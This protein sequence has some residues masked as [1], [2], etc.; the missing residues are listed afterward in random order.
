M[1]SGTFIVRSRSRSGLAYEMQH[2]PEGYAVH[3]G[4]GCEGEIFNGPL[5]CWHSKSHTVLQEDIEDMTTAV[6]NY[7]GGG[8]VAE[9][10]FNEDDLA[11]L[12][13]TICKGA[14]DAELKLFIAT[15]QH[16]GLDPFMKQIHCVMRNTKDGDKWV[17]AMTIQIGI[18]G[19]RLIADR[20]SQMEG[21]DGPQWT[22]D[23]ETWVDVP[24]DMPD[25]PMAARVGIYRK[26]IMRPFV[27]VARWS[28][29]VQTTSNG[30]PNSVWA[31]RGP[32]QLAKC[33]EAL[34]LRRAFPAEIT[35]LPQNVEYVSDLDPEW[36]PEQVR[37]QYVTEHPNVIDVAPET[38]EPA[39]AQDNPA[40]D[41]EPETPAAQNDLATAQRQ[42][43]AK[44]EDSKQT[45]T[46]KDYGEFYREL[47]AYMPNPE[48]KFDP[49]KLDLERATACLNYIRERRGELVGAAP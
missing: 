35:S 31:Q 47:S 27:A 41:E 12:K 42:I 32:E 7:Q 28:A 16:T 23:G 46:A 43:I 21:M 44:L 15:C 11:T 6:T 3:Q 45:W 5:G 2:T 36:T 25:K 26:G 18:D 29:Y 30:A 24:R 4:E 49:S 37:D 33:A 8:A 17:K 1:K 10:T 22:Y 39:N 14:S 20:T 38:P 34:G 13:N 48:D 40:Q 9:R 19:Y